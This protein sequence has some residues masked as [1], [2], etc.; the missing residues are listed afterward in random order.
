M[1]KIKKLP[2]NV[3]NQ[4]A[5]G[6]VVERPASVLKELVE[7]SIDANATK[8]VVK[9][10]NAGKKLIEVTDNGVGMDKLDARSAFEQHS[11]SKIS[12]TEDL[13]SISSLGFRGEALASISSVS[14]VTLYAKP[15]ESDVPGV[16]VV[17]QAEKTTL[18]E[19]TGAEEGVRISVEDLFGTVPARKK[20]LKGDPTE[21]KHITDTF[22]QLALS[23]SDI[24]FELY[25][26]DKLVYILP[27]SLDLKQRIFD[28]FK[29]GISENLTEVTYNSPTV[30]ISGFV[31]HPSV[32]QNDSSKQ[33]IFLNKR[34]IQER[35]VAKAVSTAFH[36][37]IPREKYPVYFLFITIDPSKVD[38]NVHPRKQEVKFEDSQQIFISVKQAVESALQR[39]LQSELKEKVG[40]EQSSSD[41][42]QKPRDFGTSHSIEGKKGQ[43]SGFRGGNSEV[44]PLKPPPS[45]ISESMKFSQALL[46]NFRNDSEGQEFALNGEFI[47]IFNTYLLTTKGDKFLIIDQHAAAE[48]IS[49]EKLMEKYEKGEQVEQQKLLTAITVDLK[50]YQVQLLEENIENFEKFGFEIEEFG[51]STFQITAIPAVFKDSDI[52]GLIEETLEMLAQVVK[53]STPLEELIDK[54]LTSMACHGSI[55]AGQK[56]E[57]SQA[58]YLISELLKCKEPYSCPHGRPIIWELPRYE[59]EK[60]FKRVK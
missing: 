51:G 20:F 28:I 38:V 42:P 25:H 9:L 17:T 31:G 11:T 32:S 44:L 16:K 34:S 24:H 7:N 2:Q 52:E 15:R 40:I 30:R 46:E 22:I 8:I 12:K 27:E 58:Q 14:K 39:D 29:A 4:I 21:F 47:Q 55:R 43:N 1:S 19:E 56:L 53:S 59:I 13:Q 26:N 57:R 3:I 5:A 41:F 23:R 48:R 6:E 33:F 18:M 54:M 45:S 36:T 49:Y 60:K 50:P 35:I 10:E 37:L